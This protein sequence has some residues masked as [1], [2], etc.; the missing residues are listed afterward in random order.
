MT[1][2]KNGLVEKEDGSKFWY[3]NGKL[4]R[5]D[6]PAREY[7]DGSK[8]WYQNGKIINVMWAFPTHINTKMI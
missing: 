8:L 4:H 6:G 3:R 5:E 1:E 2:I 7:A